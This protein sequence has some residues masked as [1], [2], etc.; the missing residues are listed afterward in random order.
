MLRNHPQVEYYRLFK[1]LEIDDIHLNDTSSD[2]IHDE[3]NRM[4]KATRNYLIDLFKEDIYRI[5]RMLQWDC[6]DWLESEVVGTKP[7]PIIPENLKQEVPAN[8]TLAPA[9]IPSL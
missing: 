5:E 3:D 2:L 4:S 7:T 8:L 9:E 1:F 6:T